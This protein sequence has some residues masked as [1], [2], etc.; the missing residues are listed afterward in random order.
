MIKLLK[1]LSLT[2]T[3]QPRPH[4]SLAHTPQPRP[5]LSLTLT[6][7]PQPHLSLALTPQPRPHLSLT[8]TPQPQPHL[9]LALTPQPRPHL[10]SALA[11]QP[12][13]SPVLGHY[14]DS[15][16][17]RIGHKRSIEED[18]EDNILLAQ[19]VEAQDDIYRN[20]REKRQ[21]N[22][23]ANRNIIF[24]VDSSGSI[25]SSTYQEVL[26]VLSSFSELFCGN[27]SIGLLTYSTH[28]DLEFCPTCHSNLGSSY[29]SVVQPKIENA[30]YHD[31]WTHTGE[32]V[33]CLSEHV[34]PSPRCPDL[35]KT[36]QV[37][38][39]TDGNHNGCLKPKE[40]LKSLQTRYPTLETY[41]IGM[42]YSISSNGVKDL[43]TD[44]FDPNNIFSVKDITE[45][46]QLLRYVTALIESGNIQCLTTQIPAPPQG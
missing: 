21:T 27:V 37:V 13:P 39:F 30:R 38:F 26:K 23:P 1:N 19:L 42:G 8:L 41:S 36:T 20:K 12:R 17:R 4:L 5:H 7:Q 45:L 40:A 35:S 6:P 9:S 31:G 14:T 32:V 11:P 24:V 2:L 34:L 3:P 29:L 43:I 25:R 10:S 15:C 46:K 28:I 22:S 18:A 33:K 44:S 16:A